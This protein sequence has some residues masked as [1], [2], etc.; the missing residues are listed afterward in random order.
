MSISIS[1]GTSY[2]PARRPCRRPRGGLPRLLVLRRRPEA[3]EAAHRRRRRCLPKRPV[4]KKRPTRQ[5]R[6]APLPIC[7]TRAKL[8]PR[9]TP[10]LEAERAIGPTEEGRRIW[11]RGEGGAVPWREWGESYNYNKEEGN[12]RFGGGARWRSGVGGRVGWWRRC[13]G[14]GTGSARVGGIEERRTG[15]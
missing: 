1:Q 11:G 3:D 15:R 13:G 6:G 4:A 9:P 8:L 2:D 7:G 14:A 10:R 5:E 12:M